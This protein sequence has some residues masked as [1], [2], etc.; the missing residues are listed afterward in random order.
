[1][2]SGHK[3]AIF[4]EPLRKLTAKSLILCGPKTKLKSQTFQEVFSPQSVPPRKKT[5]FTQS[6]QTFFAKTRKTF[7][8]KSETNLKKT[9]CFQKKP[10]KVSLGTKN[11]ERCRFYL[12]LYLFVWERSKK[13]EKNKTSLIILSPKTFL[14]R[15]KIH[16]CQT[17]SGRFYQKTGIF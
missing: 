2:I 16:F 11:A 7:R 1:M 6:R 10:Q 8:S 12:K 13:R 3:T 17:L 9:D 14:W 15:R 5:Q 4:W